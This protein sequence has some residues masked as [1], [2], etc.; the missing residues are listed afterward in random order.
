MISQ[1]LLYPVK[2]TSKSL[3]LRGPLG[4]PLRSPQNNSQ[5]Y[6]Y[7]IGKHF[8]NI[9]QYISVRQNEGQQSMTPS[10]P[11]MDAGFQTHGGRWGDIHLIEFD[12]ASLLIADEAVGHADATLP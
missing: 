7:V 9:L 2:S 10:I 8:T 6:V 4:A 1:N 5:K 12:L 11:G 3:H